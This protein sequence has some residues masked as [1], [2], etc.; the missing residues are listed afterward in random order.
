MIFTNAQIMKSISNLI[1][2]ILLG[3]LLSCQTSKS[4]LNSGSKL[5][6]DEATLSFPK[7]EG[8]ETNRGVF[9]KLGYQK[10]SKIPDLTLFSPEGVK[11][12]MSEVLA[13]NKPLLLI[14]GSYTCDVSRGNLP[15]INALILKYKD[16]VNTYLVYTIDAH[17]SDV[18]SPYSETNKVS[19]ARE[20]V[21]QNIEAKQPGTYGARKMLAQKWKQQNYISAPIIIDNPTNDFWLTYGQAPNMAYLINPDGTVYYKQAWFSYFD[22]DDAIKGWLRAHPKM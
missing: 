14:S 1:N 18:A 16:R 7:S 9:E 15:D 21:R 13:Q 20:N 12:S 2:L 10:G 17:P 6:K 22:M 5:P 19:L 8:S 4:T 11:F 3:T